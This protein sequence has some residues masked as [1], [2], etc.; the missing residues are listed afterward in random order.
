MQTISSPIPRHSRLAIRARVATLPTVTRREA[1]A[2][3]AEPLTRPYQPRQIEQCVGLLNVLRDFASAPDR[4]MVVRK[5]NGELEVWARPVAG[6][7]NN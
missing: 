4:V 7:G 2:A 5:R 6:P 1:K 3:R